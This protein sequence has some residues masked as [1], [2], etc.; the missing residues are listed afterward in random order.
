MF[1][2]IYDEAGAKTEKDKE[3]EFG[4]VSGFILTDKEKEVLLI[5]KI[6]EIV[7]KHNLEGLKKLHISAINSKEKKDILQEEVLSLLNNLDIVWTYNGTKISNFHS[8]EK[9]E[10]KRFA[11]P[12]LYENCIINTFGNVVDYYSIYHA[13]SNKEIEFI[14]DSID[15]EIK[16]SLSHLLQRLLN[17]KEKEEIPIYKGYDK[18]KRKPILESLLKVEN[19]LESIIF[20]KYTIK[21]E[22]SYLTFVADILTYHT[23]K[24]L[25]NNSLEE[26]INNHKIMK[27][28]LCKYLF[29]Y[30]KE[31]DN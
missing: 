12:T 10:R 26:G 18:E 9:G 4:V 1:K 3:H 7:K 29:L 16:D 15:K 8:F 19:N 23:F 17:I 31:I 21:S 2:F 6:K 13:K 28:H 22:D 27:N 24:I 25:K 11:L 14:S 30:Y 5:K 20:P